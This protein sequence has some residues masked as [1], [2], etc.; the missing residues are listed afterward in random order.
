VFVAD[1]E[2]RRNNKRD[3]RSNGELESRSD[4]SLE[5][6]SDSRLAEPSTAGVFQ[7]D[8]VNAGRGRSG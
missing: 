4:C 8:F 5:S 7:I 3:S 2:S 1:V 6:R